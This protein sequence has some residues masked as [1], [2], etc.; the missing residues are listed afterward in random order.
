V[1]REYTDGSFTTLKPRPPE[2]RYLGMLGPIL[3]GE[4]GDT[5]RV[6]F[7]NNA[8]RPYSMQHQRR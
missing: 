2:E 4:V 5:I 6:V 3:R 7:K 1:Y 8:S